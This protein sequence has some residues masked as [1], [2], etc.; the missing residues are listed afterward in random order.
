V[1]ELTETYEVTVIGGGPGGY[2][3]ALRAAQ[4]GAKVAIVE[5]GRFGGVCNNFGCIPTKTMLRAA[6]LIDQIERGAQFGISAEKLSI[7]FGA[8]VRYKKMVVDHLSKSIEELLERS[9]VEIYRGRGRLGRKGEVVVD[10]GTRLVTKSTIIATGS[11]PLRPP[12][13]GIEGRKVLTGEEATEIEEVPSSVVITGGGAEGT[14]FACIFA[15]LG[16]KVTLV[17]MKPRLLPLEDRE[18]GVRLRQA[19]KR[20][21]VEVLTDTKVT[22]IADLNGGKEITLVS[23]REAKVRCD[24]VVL[25]LGRRPNSEG[26]GLEDNGVVM[27]GWRIKVNDRMETSTPG[28]YAVGDV[29]GGFF[30]HEAMMGGCVAAENAMGDRR[31]LDRKAIPRCIYTIPEVAAVGM[32]E[33]QA[34]ASGREVKTGKF[35]FAANGRAWTMGE[36]EGAI[37]VVADGSSLEI[38]GVHMIG[39]M[40]SE[41]I[42]EACL[43]MSQGAKIDNIGWMM[44]AHP[45]LSEVFREA[46]LDCEGRSLHK[47]RL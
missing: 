5:Q 32:T 33:D 42:A 7:D 12:I 31:S 37:K 21:G 24:L 19:F 35:S 39:P 10:D 41:L 14:E 17:E 36:T 38:L 43:A 8:L 25:A 13:P 30:A 40:V 2:V 26:L 28:I 34:R 20:H 11:R 47:S 15:K 44:H 18:L 22:A 46:M 16:A 3:A 9:G 45:T 29:T 23:E 6:E 4:L 1:A 27:E